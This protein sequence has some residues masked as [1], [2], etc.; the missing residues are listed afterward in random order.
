[1]FKNKKQK[2]Q[3]EDVV[4]ASGVTMSPALAK[5][6]ERKQNGESA[7]A[8]KVKEKKVDLKDTSDI[9]EETIIF[10]RKPKLAPT[11][12]VI[13]DRELRDKASEILRKDKRTMTEFIHKHLIDLVNGEN[14]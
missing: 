13:I 11:I 9:P 14:K 6:I 4:T 2:T 5:I 8:K 3:Q 7:P 1:M 10:K 12:S